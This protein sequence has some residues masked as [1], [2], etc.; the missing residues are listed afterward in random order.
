MKTKLVHLYEKHRFA[1]AVITAIFVFVFSAG[2]LVL[3][4]GET[5]EPNDSHVV[6]LYI[7]G[8]ELSIPSRAKTVG[9]FIANTKLEVGEY[10]SVEPD[11]DQVIDAD[12]FRI[13]VTRARPYIVRDGQKEYAS[14]SAHTSARLVA[15]SAGIQLKPADVVEFLPPSL[16][17]PET[18]GRVVA[19]TRSK[20]VTLTL[21]GTPQVVYTNATTVGDLFS[22]LGIIPAEGDEVTPAETVSLTDGLQVYVNRNG[23]QVVTE[24]LLIEPPVEYIQD[25]SLTLGSLVTKD[26][27]APGKRVVTFE[28]TTE[29]DREISRKEISSI[30]LEQ[31]RTKV[32][33]RGRAAGQVGAEKQ[34][35]MALAGITPEEFA[36]ADYIITRES[37]WC[38][39]KWQGQWGY[40]PP[41]YEERHAPN[42]PGVGFGLCQSTPQ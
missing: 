39:T 4:N 29:N 33:A 37:G 11:R 12:L 6:S 34:E 42:T 38:A 19:I 22:E 41:F 1:A 21:Y 26:P 16:D 27:G 5:L 24:E 18:L 10:D 23:I 15:E 28:I 25:D 40:C 20:Q 9:E 17:D 36:A 8:E 2:G 7:D 31:P 30:L 3:V 35:L 14:L 32:V 13:R